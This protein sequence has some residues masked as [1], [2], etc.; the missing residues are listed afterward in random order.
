LTL[1]P[2]AVLKLD[3]RRAAEPTAAP[4][5]PARE[6]RPNIVASPS[7]GPAESWWTSRATAGEVRPGFSRQEILKPAEEQ[8]RGP[9]GVLTRLSELL[10][11]LSRTA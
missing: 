2:P 3:L 6:Q 11:E 9:Q 10:T 1:T 5:R 4:V 8:P 7:G